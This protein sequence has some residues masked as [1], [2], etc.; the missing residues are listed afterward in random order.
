MPCAASRYLCWRPTDHA[1]EWAGL[2]PYA[3][4]GLPVTGAVPGR[5]GLFVSTGHGLSGITLAAVSAQ[6]LAPHVL[7]GPEPS[8]LAPLSPARFARTHESSGTSLTI[9]R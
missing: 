6:L 9:G 5:P 2:R 8:E 1:F 4:A 7:D 3:P